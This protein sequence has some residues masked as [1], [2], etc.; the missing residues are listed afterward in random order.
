MPLAFDMPYEDLLTYAGTNPRPD[1]FDEFWDKGLAELA[2]VDPQVELVPAAFGAP[3]ARCEHL[4]FTGTGGA[5]V[6]A[7]LVRPPLDGEPAPAVLQFHGYGGESAQWTDLLAYAALGY[8]IAGLDVR[9]QVGYATT[10]MRPNRFTLMHHVVAGLDEEPEQLIY[11][12]VFLDTVRLARIVMG[13]DGVDPARVATTGASQGGGLSLA[14]AALEPRVRLVASIFPFLSDYRRAY[15]LSLDTA[16]YNEIAEWFRKRDPRHLR[17]TE[18]FTR[19]GYID[20]QHLAPRIRATVDLTVGLE[21][22]VCP[23]STQFAAYN[24]ITSEKSLRLYPDHGHD[25]LPGLED[26]IYLLLGTL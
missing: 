19:L 5:R 3:F 1:D 7:K 24:K 4:Y 12:H 6:H 2:T 26:D 15:D 14:C 23:P 16:P 8:T 18:I 10:D 20:V 22:E 17:E 13:L 21:D 11:R 25:D 9:G